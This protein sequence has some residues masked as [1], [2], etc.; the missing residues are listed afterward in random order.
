MNNISGHDFNFFVNTNFTPKR[1]NVPH[2]LKRWNTL[3]L[4]SPKIKLP[5]IRQGGSSQKLA[6]T[7]F[8]TRGTRFLRTHW[9]WYHIFTQSYAR[10]T[11]PIT[12]TLKKNKPF[13]WTLA[14]EEA[15]N[16]LKKAFISEPILTL[17]DFTK[18]FLVTT[19]A[20]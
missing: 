2:A 6:F 15:F 19:D 18:P 8:Y 3:D 16:I 10:I 12:S 4:S 9:G 13:L 20:R 14:T 17:L 7:Q 5:P 1:A 11:S